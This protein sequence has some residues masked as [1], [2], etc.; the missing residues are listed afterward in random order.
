MIHQY[1]ISIMLTFMFIL[2][3]PKKRQNALY[4]STNL[5]TIWK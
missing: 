5:L 1:C 2:V 4:A 3:S